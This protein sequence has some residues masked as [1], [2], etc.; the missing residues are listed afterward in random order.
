MKEYVVGAVSGIIMFF[1][2]VL[3]VAVGIWQLAYSGGELIPIILGV[4]LLVLCFIL[5]IG[6]FTLQP[7]EGAVLTLFGEYKGTVKKA[8]WRWTNPLYMKE[9]ISLRSRNL[10][11]DRLKVNDAIGNPIEI[12]A[13][14]VWKVE[15][16]AAA[17]FDVQNY[18][19]YVR[20]QSESSIRHLA[21]VFP[22]DSSEDSNQISLRGCSEEVIGELKKELQGSLAKAGVVVEEARITHLA[23]AP[24]IA[25][26]MLQRQQATAII[27]AR[28]KIVEGAVGMVQMALNKLNEDSIVE[29]DEERKAAMVSNLL[30]VL[31][32][33]RNTQPIINAGTLHH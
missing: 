8:G 11:G 23:Y 25:A 28:Q 29:L 33:E 16:T 5:S 10:N 18:N 32:G 21:S 22:Y 27:A 20:I 26:A 4:G 9:K 13:V 1:V 31:C 12:A 30:V 19:D 14:I 15:N 17:L 24:E 3:L 7:N 2:E 6:F